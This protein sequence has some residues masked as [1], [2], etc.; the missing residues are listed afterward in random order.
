MTTPSRSLRCRHCHADNPV[1]ATRCWLCDA[2]DWVPRSRTAAKIDT[3]GGSG[4]LGLIAM[5]NALVGVM[6]M[7]AIGIGQAS[8]VLAF[9]VALV[10]WIALGS[11]G[12]IGLERAGVRNPF[13]RAIAAVGIVLGTLVLAVVSVLILLNLICS[14]SGGHA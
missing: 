6:I 9:G 1:D 11:A 4:T 13:L 7:V 14:V 10:W 2:A 8:S 3:P 12:F 5:M